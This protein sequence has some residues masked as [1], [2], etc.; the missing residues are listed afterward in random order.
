MN[1]AAKLFGF[2]VLGLGVFQSLAAPQPG[3]L[4]REYIWKPGGKY[5]VLNAT[6][7][8]L[9]LPDELDLGDATKAEVVLEIGNAHLGFEDLAM[10]VNGGEWR[11]IAFPA[12][13]PKEPSPSV[14]FHQWQPT[15][16]LPLAELR[17]GSDNQFQ[18]RI[19]PLIPITK[20]T[21]PAYTCVYSV[22][23]RVYYD[24]ARKP[25]PS[26]R[27]TA[28]AAGGTLGEKAELAADAGSPNGPVTQVDFVGHYEDVNYEGDG[29]FTQWHGMRQQG[30]LVNHL[31]SADGAAKKIVWDLAWVPDQREPMQVAARIVD[32]TGLIYFTE[33]VGGLKLVRP[34][35]SVE[36]C[37]PYDVPRAFT[38]CQ[39]GKWIEPG[40]RTEKF[41]VAGDP[42]R[43]IDGRFVMS[44]WNA[45]A[46]S[47]YALNGTP[48]EKP[49]LT[50]GGGSH[51]FFSLPLRPLTLLQRGENTLSTVPGPARQSDIHWP[52]VMVLVK[53]AT[54]PVRGADVSPAPAQTLPGTFSYSWVGNSFMDHAAKAWVPDEVRD[55]CVSSN[56]VVFTAGYAEAGGSG[57]ALSNG[58]FFGRYSGFKS[59]FG[60]PV[61]AVATDGTNVYWGGGNGV[62]RYGFASSKTPNLSLLKGS[63]ITGVACKDGELYLSDYSKNLIRVYATSTMTQSR[64]WSCLRPGKIAVDHSNHVW[65]IQ[66]A[67]GSNPNTILT[68]TQILSF[69]DTGAPGPSISDVTNPLA[70]TVNGSNQLLVGGLDEASQIR[71]Y[72]NLGGTP[73]LAGTFGTK[74]GIF[75]G[76]PGLHEPLKFHQIR[77]LGVDAAGNIYVCMMYGAKSWGQSV[78][79]YTSGGKPLWEVHGFDYVECVTLDPDS[80]TDGYDHQHHFTFDWSKSDGKEWAFKGFTVNRFKYAQDPRVT[81]GGGFRAGAAAFRVSGKLFLAESDQNGYPLNIYRFN[82]AMDG[83]VA[84]PS[85]TFSDGNPEK[86]SRDAN[87]NGQF[88]PG[89]TAPGASGYFQYHYI[90][91][92]GGV[93]RIG[94]AAGPATITYYPCQGLDGTGN[95]IYSAATST[96]WKTPAEFSCIRKVVYDTKND[97]MYLGGQSVSSVEDAVVR[98]CRYNNWSGTRTKAWDAIIPYEDKSYTPET[99]YGAGRALSVR[100]AGQYLF[101]QY[102]Y[103]YIR[104]HDKDSGDYLGTIRPSLH[105]LKG[106]GGQVDITHGMTAYQRANGEYVIFTEDAGHNLVLMTRW[107]PSATMTPAVPIAPRNSP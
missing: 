93:C 60:D 74:G 50:N 69:S 102:G 76:T 42:A 55:L 88:D 57:L 99:S 14:Y 26:G 10:Q 12:L 44:A 59:G 75:S 38:S 87:G 65:V 71:I 92:N 66:Y 45:P 51:F 7:S 83:E 40:P 100:Q 36:L 96:T 101:I 89:E 70:I 8:P 9:A 82:S 58:A 37:K 30:R 39:Y 27:I 64:E 104:V 49:E 106:G 52:G 54:D 32:S 94:N 79:A 11:P 25:H 13:G 31:G 34:G 41:V 85:V 61:K 62:Q 3:D 33:A 6:Q 22:V 53:Y 78:E 95:P 86:I 24:A 16:P 105:G 23:F 1:H 80:E 97:I 107:N 90:T 63:S 84:I 19:G 15:V 28:P 2:W 67:D 98:L 56:G 18:L 81:F 68:G 43:I 29:V 35:V 73:S 17:G 48:L 77:G 103:G 72:G 20:G 5:H 4:F 91:P 21:H 47:G 46:W